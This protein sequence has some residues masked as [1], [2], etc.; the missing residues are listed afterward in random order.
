MAPVPVAGADAAAG[1]AME[2]LEV[3]V[4]T[5]SPLWADPDTATISAPLPCL[6]LNG[7]SAN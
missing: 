2:C 4:R 1:Q 5:S 7:R 3:A 6:L